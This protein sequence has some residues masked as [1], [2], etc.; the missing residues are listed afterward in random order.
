MELSTASEEHDMVDFMM[1]VHIVCEQSGDFGEDFSE[2]RRKDIYNVFVAGR[3]FVPQL[4][5]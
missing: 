3:M 2:R 4:F 1:P 5:V